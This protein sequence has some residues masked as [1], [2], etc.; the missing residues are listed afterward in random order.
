MLSGTCFPMEYIVTFISETSRLSPARCQDLSIMRK[1]VQ[2]L[3]LLQEFLKDATMRP[4]GRAKFFRD[5][6]RFGFLNSKMLNLPL[7]YLFWVIFLKICLFLAHFVCA[8]LSNRNIGRA[9][10]I[11]F[12]KS[13][14]W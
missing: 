14:A 1:K 3:V 5:R 8:K 10:K 13:E 9:K 2:P 4:H 12:R 6:A 7:F 11:A